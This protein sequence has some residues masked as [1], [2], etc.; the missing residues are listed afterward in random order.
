MTNAPLN[1]YRF[2]QNNSGGEFH[3]DDAVSVEVLIQAA[4]ANEANHKAKEVGIYFD[5]VDKGID[6]ECCGDRWWAVDH[7]L[8]SFVTYDRSN[9]WNGVTRKD[10]REY[11]QVVADDD[12]WATDKP[13]VIVYFAD[14]TVERFTGKSQ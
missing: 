3:I 1:F 9:G 2:R 12:W 13:S 10:V 6:C 14:G 11:A 8:E 4:S 5:G 7:P